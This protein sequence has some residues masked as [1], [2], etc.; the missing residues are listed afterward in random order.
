M[1]NKKLSLIVAAFSLFTVNSV[2]GQDYRSVVENYLKTTTSISKNVNNREFTISSEDPSASL[3]GTV[4]NIQQTYDGIPVFGNYSTFLIRDNQ[5]LNFVGNFTKNSAKSSSQAGSSASILEKVVKNMSLSDSQGYIT[6]LAE[7]E[8]KTPTLVYY[9]DGNDLILS[10]ELEFYEQKSSNLWHIV[11]N[12]V[13]GEIYSKQ[14]L[15]IS[16]NFVHGAYGRDESHNA[17]T[18]NTLVLN[19]QNQQNKFTASLLVNNA[20]YRVVPFPTEAPSFG[21]RVLLTNPW[22]LT[23]SPLG[24]QND[25]TTEYTMT[26]G[27]NAYAYTD[28]LSTNAI[29]ASADGGSSHVFD[30]PFDPSLGL[31]SYKN[32][33]LTNLFYANNYVHDA[34]YK[35][36]FTETAKNFQAYNFGLGG[37]QNDYVLAEARDGASVPDLSLGYYDNSNFSTPTD[38]QRPRMQMY[39]WLGATPWFIYNAPSTVA[40]TGIDQ[41]GLGYFGTQLWKQSVTADV[42]ISP[43]LD[44]C[45][46]LPANSLS[47]KIG[48]AQRGTCPFAQKVKNLQDAG[49]IAAIIYNS[50]DTANQNPG[51]AVTNMSTDGTITGITIPSVFLAE[52]KGEQIV[53]MINS[54]QT[55]NVTLQLPT[56]DG[57]MD[58]GVMAH[59]YGHG[60]S[61]R[62]TG[63]SVACL[64]QNVDQEQMGEGWSDFIALMLTMRATDTKDVPRGIGTYVIGEAST[65][66]G[67]RQA[68]YSPDFAI[69]PYTYA[70]TNSMT[71]AHDIGFVWATILW[72][73]HWKYAEQYGFSN[74][75]VANPNS[76]SGK[77]FQAVVDGLKLQGCYPTFIEGRNGIL[78]ADQAETGG[79]NRCLIWNVFANRGVGVNAS[80]GSKTDMTDQVPDFNPPTDCI[81]GV[82]DIPAEKA[83]S[84]YPNPTKDEFFVN[85]KNNILGKVNVEIYDASGKLVSDQQIDPSI[86]EAVNTQK[87]PNGNYLLKISGI[88]VS[89]SSKIIIKK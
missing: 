5:V 70:D 2:F 86:Q 51:E 47:G 8:I 44:A 82:N 80:S 9:D 63:T 55:V 67:I 37:N 18:E 19:P 88:G 81:L 65:G 84:I 34:L 43:T 76:G 38:G 71:E 89:Y 29:G 12:A 14:N 10:Y 26:R 48:I 66:L 6:Q 49:A 20:Q 46:A 57:C 45:T 32:A 52:S 15:T 59:E 4:V 40:G 62:T 3:K 64:N 42:A 54:S 23:A 83:I 50:P 25:N 53:S 24:W 21:D 85:F 61:N 39:I 36:G 13:S 74:D 28:E 31:D 68:K 17:G 30:F 77:A 69:N 73:L 16:C 41:I 1:K 78:A 35:F 79:E 27:N 11:A 56:Y 87:L 72:D 60:L 22:D 75:I 58:N 7:G 33:A